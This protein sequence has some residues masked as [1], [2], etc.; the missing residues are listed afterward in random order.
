MSV[1]NAHFVR[2]NADREVVA[3]YDAGLS[4]DP[5][6]EQPARRAGGW[7]AQQLSRRHRDFVASFQDVVT[8]EVDGL[9]E[10][11]FCHGSPRSEDEII[12]QL[13]P[14]DRLVE[15]LSATRE[16]VVVC[17]H[18]HMQFDRRCGETR[19]LN[20]GSVGMPY[21][22]RRGAFWLLLGPDADFRRTEYDVDGFVA[23]VRESDYFDAD[24]L[25][26]IL[27]T[28]PSPD[29]VAAFFEGIGP[30]PTLG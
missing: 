25:A 30:E 13:T 14:E 3:A 8:L 29:E 2:G 28:P 9:G 5:E 18:T 12:T 26:A 24:D 15:F 1:E 20:A 23:Q 10:T 21:E 22:G 11:L 6:E 17:G 7:A 19:V 27:L 4:F 16:H